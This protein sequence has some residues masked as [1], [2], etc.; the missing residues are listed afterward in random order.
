MAASQAELV[1]EGVRY[2]VQ[3]DTTSST[4]MDCAREIS[5]YAFA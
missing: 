4:A 3:V 2:D 1:H 5:V